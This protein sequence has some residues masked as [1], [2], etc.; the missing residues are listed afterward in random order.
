M[1]TWSGSWNKTRKRIEA[2]LRL[3]PLVFLTLKLV[4]IEPP[5]IWQL[6]FRFLYLITGSRGGSCSCASTPVSCDSLHPPNC[7]SNLRGSGLHCDPVLCWIYKKLL[8]FSFFLVIRTWVMTF[9]LLMCQIGN[10]K[11]P[12]GF[13]SKKF[14]ASCKKHF[15]VYFIDTRILLAKLSFVCFANRSPEP[16][17]CWLNNWITHYDKPVS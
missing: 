2:P 17:F 8:I 9:K 16:R 13:S 6:Q 7:L 5:T 11:S 14:I 10:H 12:S 4:H 15:H 1:R 3:G